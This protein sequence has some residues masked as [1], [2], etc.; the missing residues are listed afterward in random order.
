M[1]LTRTRVVIVYIVAE[2][3]AL[4]QENLKDRIRPK[5]SSS[6]GEDPTGDLKNVPVGDHF[7]GARPKH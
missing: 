4:Y 3:S 5:V 1:Q 2:K 6:S 7:H